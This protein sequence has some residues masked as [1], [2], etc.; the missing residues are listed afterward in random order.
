MNEVTTV[1]NLEEDTG[2]GK[3]FR[4]QYQNFYTYIVNTIS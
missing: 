3:T 1:Q 4:H 2:G